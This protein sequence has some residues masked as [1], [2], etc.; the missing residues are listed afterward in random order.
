MPAPTSGGTIMPGTYY[1]TSSTL[2]QGSTQTSLLAVQGTELISATEI[3]RVE[4]I[5]G[6][7][8]GYI[9]Y[10]Y[11]LSGTTLNATVDCAGSTATGSEGYDATS[12]GYTTYV[13]GSNTVNVWTRQ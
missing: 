13:A 1:L 4:N 12:T 10:A 8:D 2:Y 11:T 6:G 5:N 9:D 3:T 7:A